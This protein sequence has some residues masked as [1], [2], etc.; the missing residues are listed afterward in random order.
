MILCKIPIVC[1]VPCVADVAAMKAPPLGFSAEPCYTITNWKC[2]VAQ[3]HSGEAQTSA[4]KFIPVLASAGIATDAIPVAP[5]IM[6]PATETDPIANFSLL[7]PDARE[8]P[9]F[10]IFQNWAEPCAGP[11]WE[12]LVWKTHGHHLSAKLLSK[13]ADNMARGPL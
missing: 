10:W 8:A 12:L 1:R 4:L 13:E 2:A 3:E 6:G 7:R 9:F 11:R 5:K